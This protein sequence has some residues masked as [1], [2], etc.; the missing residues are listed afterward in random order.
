MAHK[1][2]T[3]SVDISIC[4]F[5]CTNSNYKFLQ[6]GSSQG[7]LST[8]DEV[9]TP[10]GAELTIPRRNLLVVPC[11]IWWVSLVEEVKKDI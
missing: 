3:G 8:L 7:V 11:I 4:T 1:E 2:A 9:A 5:Y 6:R 10:L